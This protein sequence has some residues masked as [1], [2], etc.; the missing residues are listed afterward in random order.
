MTERMTNSSA[1]TTESWNHT[2]NELENYSGYLP[3]LKS[4]L[5]SS[6]MCCA[7]KETAIPP[8]A[9]PLSLLPVLTLEPI[10]LVACFLIQHSDGTIGHCLRVLV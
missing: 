1:Q 2:F 5:Q 3:G 10:M 7:S 9:V 8:Q 6:R 4:A